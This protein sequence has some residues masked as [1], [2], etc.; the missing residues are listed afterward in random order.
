MMRLLP[1]T[2]VMALATAPIFAQRDGQG[3]ETGFDRQ[4]R[5]TDDQPIRQF[6]QSK[7]NI[8]VKD[9]AE[10]LEISGDVRFEYRHL[11]EKGLRISIDESSRTFFQKYEWLRGDGKKDYQNQLISKNDFDVDFN[12]KIKYT[13]QRAWMSAH[14]QY[15][16]SAGIRANNECFGAANIDDVVAIRDSRRGCKGSGEGNA[17]NLKRAFMGYNVYADGKKRFDIE[18]GRR[19]LDDIYE[20]EIQFSNRFDG[21][22]F[23][24]T[25]AIDQ[26]ADWYCYLGGFVIDERVNHIGG[27]AEV[28]ILNLLDTGFDLKYSYINWN[29]KKTNRCDFDYARGN[30]F[31]N[32]QITLT[33]NFNPD[34]FCGIPAQLYGAFLINHAAKKNTLVGIQSKGFHTVKNRENI[35]AYLGLYVGE[36]DKAGEWSID[37]LYQYVQAQ[38]VSDCDVSGIGRGNILNERFTDIYYIDVTRNEG[39]DI[40]GAGDVII[41]RRGNANYQGLKLEGLYAITDNLSIDMLYEFSFALNRHLGGR[42]FYSD[43]KLESIYAF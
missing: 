21:I 27:A 32:S 9:K 2:L 30:D 14:V 16:N 38:A 6:V 40:T 25:S 5:E 33:Y 29:H 1:L 3:Q 8:D 20:S 17:V 41:P 19:K 26:I 31:R 24:Y 35:G 37:I 43:F 7:E 34:L 15:D 11:N 13:Y 12:L 18:V 36:A 4:L 10:N 23:K 22:L 42:H 39:R 28:G